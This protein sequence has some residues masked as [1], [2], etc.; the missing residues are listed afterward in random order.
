MLAASD[1]SISCS[2][3]CVFLQANRYEVRDQ[4]G[5][6]VALLAEDLGGFGKSVGRQLLRTR[7]PFTA[8][9]FSPDGP[10]DIAL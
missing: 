3:A 4:D 5:T 9:V 1:R 8:T 6:I 10:S 7:R 2:V